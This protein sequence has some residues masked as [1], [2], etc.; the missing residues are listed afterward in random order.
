MLI[1][2]RHCLAMP[3]ATGL[4]APHAAAATSDAA[5]AD[6]FPAQDPD[7]VK[8]MVVVSHGNHERVEALLKDSPRLANATYDWGFGDWETCLGAAS[9]TGR[10]K[11]AA[12]LLEAGARPDIFAMTMLGKL[13][14]V[15]AM[16]QAQPGLQKTRGPHGLTL[17][18]HARMGGDDAV[19]VL[20]YL[21]AL[22]GADVPYK[23]EPL[24]DADKAAILGDYTYGPGEDQRFKIL[25]PDKDTHLA[26][27]RGKN[28]PRQLF[29]QGGL[30]FHPI[31]APETHL[32]FTVA[33]GK[34][35]VTVTNPA[36]GVVGQR[37]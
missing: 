14:A 35:S 36:P 10:K 9:H 25:I 8:E 12:A 22:E 4:L 33:N 19:K 13:E 30:V 17:M 28:F 21:L 26:V 34:T 6:S 3:F 5:P 2:R 18:H 29:H 1:S 23:D 15:K 37:L 16:I 27:R 32:A 7:L 20:E 11:I 31:G 24:N